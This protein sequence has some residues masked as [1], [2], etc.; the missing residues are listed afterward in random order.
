MCAALHPPLVNTR[1]YVKDTNSSCP[2]QPCETLDYYASV[3]HCN[4]TQ[5]ILMPGLHTLSR[6]FTLSYLENIAFI[7]GDD[8]S[9]TENSTG[10]GNV[11]IQCNTTVGFVFEHVKLLTLKHVRIF[12]CGRRIPNEIFNCSNEL[13]HACQAAVTFKTVHTLV[14]LSVSVYASYGYGVAADG[15][16]GNSTIEECTFKRNEG[17]PDQFVGGNFLGKYEHCPEEYTREQINLAIRRSKFSK[18]YTEYSS[19]STDDL[20]QSRASGVSLILTCTNTSIHLLEVDLNCNMAYSYSSKGG[21]LFVLFES[22][23]YTSSR[24]IVENSR[25]THGAAK[26]GGGAYILIKHPQAK[27]TANTSAKS[28]TNLIAFRNT[29]FTSNKG[30]VRGGALYLLFKTANEPNPNIQG[31]VEITSCYFKDNI[32]KE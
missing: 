17:R 24:V 1:H 29:N 31:Q 32:L 8:M 18:G 11:N 14:M 2:G 20:F 15:L 3:S 7:G 13:H 5:F 19:E 4:N 26:M 9:D 6:N 16:Y 30:E 25:I 10:L 22:T 23:L 28:G 12:H 21:N 27:P